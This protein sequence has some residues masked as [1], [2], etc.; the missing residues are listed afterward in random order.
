MKTNVKLK[1][2]KITNNT[3]E[4]LVKVKGKNLQNFFEFEE[5]LKGNKKKEFEQLKFKDLFES[6][7]FTIKHISILANESFLQIHKVFSVNNI[8][9]QEKSQKNANYSGL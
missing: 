9:S 8:N 4:L 2:K 5:V 3:Q 7:P 1:I 6:S